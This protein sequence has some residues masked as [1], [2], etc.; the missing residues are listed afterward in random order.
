M[1]RLRNTLFSAALLTGVAAVGLTPALAETA[2]SAASPAAAQSEVHHHGKAWMTPGQLVDGRIAFLKAE[3]KI[4]SAQEAPWQQFAAVMHQNAQSLDQALATAR[5]HGG[6]AMNAVER[7]EMRGQFAQV[8]A[9]NQAR[10]L[11]AFKPL[12]ASLS[13][14]QQQVANT[15]M[16]RHGGGQHGWRHRA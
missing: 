2:P 5:Q 8:R 13:P 6:A 14:D 4:T 1:T 12:Y 3:L 11:T 7:M 15:L 16:T 10:L 9:A